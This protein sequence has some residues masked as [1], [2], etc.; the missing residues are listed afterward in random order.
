MYHSTICL[1]YQHKKVVDDYYGIYYGMYLHNS[2][3]SHL[4]YHILDILGIFWSNYPLSKWK[5]TKLM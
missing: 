1:F 3:E 2:L 5:V 4:V